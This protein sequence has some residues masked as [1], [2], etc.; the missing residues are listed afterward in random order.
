M[1]NIS[2]RTAIKTALVGGAA[3]AVSGL[4]A[5]N[6]AKKKKAETKEPLKGNVRHSVS[7]WGVSVTIR[8][9]NFVGYV[10]I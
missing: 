7:K 1:E 5:A 3:L 4:E 10:K 6:P 8:W 2:R 9:K